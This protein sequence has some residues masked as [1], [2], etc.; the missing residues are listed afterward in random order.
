MRKCKVLAALAGG[1]QRRRRRCLGQPP[2]PASWRVALAGTGSGWARQSPP[3][4]WTAASQLAGA[5]GRPS[6]WHRRRRIQMHERSFCMH[7]GRPTDDGSEEFSATISSHHAQRF[8]IPFK[9][10]LTLPPDKR[11]REA[12][13]STVCSLVCLPLP[14]D[15]APSQGRWRW[16]RKHFPPL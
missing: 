3:A 2:L 11:L 14:S 9:H 16:R 5:G 10:P 4:S 12:L 6:R 7:A 1:W 15:K 8:Q 13:H